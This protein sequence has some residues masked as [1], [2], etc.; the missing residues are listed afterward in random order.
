MHIQKIYFGAP[1]TGKSYVVQKYIEE[2]NNSKSFRAIVHPEYT[3]SDFVGQLLPEKDEKDDIKFKFKRGVFTEALKEAFN[4]SSKK[5]FLILEEISRGNVAAIFG[6]I[7]QLLDRNKFSQSRYPINNSQIANE[8]E[9]IVGNEVYLPTNFNII[10]TVNM[11]DQNVFPMDTAFKRR[12]EWEYISAQPVVDEYGNTK[13]RLNN[14]KLI[15]PIDSNRGND[16][17]TNW[18]SFYT[19]LNNFITDNENGLG[20]N[21]DKQIGQFFIEFNENLI[22][23]SY[24]KNEEIKMKAISEIN[25]QIKN[26]LLLYLWQDIHSNSIFTNNI[27]MFDEQVVNFDYLYFE[28]ENERVFSQVFIELFLKKDNFLYE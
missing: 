15:I 20:K 10:G 24:S 22:E 4:D 23:N 5:V 13:N 1:G 21:D 25:K 19:S 9:Q 11:N 16:I 2:N 12:F 17:Q 14:P 8:I 6:D 18:L 27:S 7:F 26:K 28:Y 3:Y